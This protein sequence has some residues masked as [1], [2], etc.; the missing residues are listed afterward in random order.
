MAYSITSYGTPLYFGEHA[1]VDGLILSSVSFNSTSS[2]IERR[3]QMGR[4]VNVTYYDE[5]GSW[6]ADGACIAASASAATGTG[7]LVLDD[8]LVKGARLTAIEAAIPTGLFSSAV[9][10][11]SIDDVNTSSSSEDVSTVSL[12]GSLYADLPGITA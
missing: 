6:S 5:G 12:S 10:I 4:M 8:A 9:V 2:K 7:A 11:A 1:T 3:G